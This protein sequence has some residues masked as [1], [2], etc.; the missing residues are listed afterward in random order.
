MNYTIEDFQ[1]EMENAETPD[2]MNGVINNLL[3]SDIDVSDPEIK[4]MI[5]EYRAQI[6]DYRT[7]MLIED[8]KVSNDWIELGK[9]ELYKCKK[10][11]LSYIE[12]NRYYVR[13]DDI[14]S[15]NIERLK[16][17]MDRLKPE[18]I[19]R[20]NSMEHLIWIISDNGIGTNKA[21]RVFTK[22]DGRFEE[23]FEKI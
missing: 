23:Y 12:G 15:E 2:Q 10:N 3:D 16:E 14:K 7:D 21:R 5:L 17:V 11:I 1:L 6:E 19:E 22:H 18:V 13:I 8:D 4:Q 9:C 20:I